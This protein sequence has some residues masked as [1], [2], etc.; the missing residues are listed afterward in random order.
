MVG[1]ETSITFVSQHALV[2]EALEATLPRLRELF[3]GEG[4]NLG[5]VDISSGEGRSNGNDDAASADDMQSNGQTDAHADPAM[6]S[7]SDE[8]RTHQL[9]SLVDTFA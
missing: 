2:R 1:E 5:E 3:S 4:L 8:A 6:V 7:S 9:D